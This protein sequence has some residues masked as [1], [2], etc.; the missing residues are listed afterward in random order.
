MS[1][2]NY[3]DTP[4]ISVGPRR[5]PFAAYPTAADTAQHGI[6]PLPAVL[7]LVDFERARPYRSR[8]Y[9]IAAA[10]RLTAQQV[11]EMAHV[12]AS[13][14]A[15]REA[16]CRHLEPPAYPSAAL[17]S[18]RHSDPFGTQAWGTWS[19]ETLLFWFIRL[20]ILTDPASPL[21]AI[22]LNHEVLLLSLAM[23]DRQGN[24]AGGAIN[25]ALPPVDL[26]PEFRS[27]DPFL[28]AVLAYV[29]PV[30]KL[31]STQDA[32][33]IAALSAQYPAF[34]AA[35]ADGKVGHHFMVARSDALA[36]VDAFELV[37]SSAEHFQAL[38]F[39]YMVVE[40]T[41]QWTGAAC[42]VLGGVRV[43]FSPFRARPAVPQSAAPLPE[44]VTSPDGYLS[45]KDSGSMLYVI[46]LD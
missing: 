40:A 3:V 8:R 16:Q 32:E 12:V 17:A 38:G 42:E 31:L 18:T 20:C 39:A 43:H 15:R 41:N 22:E 6:Q 36:T 33:A 25:E 1:I 37:A 45:D 11:M 44:L 4:V 14:F 30:I 7:P 19:K 9:P 27:G 29:E 28:D 35:Y 10:D 5:L 34:H 46:R 21:G 13:S 26:L 2:S 24:I 23:I